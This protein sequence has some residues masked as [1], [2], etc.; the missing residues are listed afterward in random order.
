MGTRIH[1]ERARA[2]STVIFY[3]CV[4]RCYAGFV[5]N[6]RRK[7]WSKVIR[8]EEKSSDSEFDSLYLR[9]VL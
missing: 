6:A 3:L 2:R 4:G 8:V 7:K 9:L 5:K 1:E